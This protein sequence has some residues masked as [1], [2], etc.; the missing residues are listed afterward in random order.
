MP[1]QRIRGTLRPNLVMEIDNQKGAQFRVQ[2]E[3][4]V[5]K[6]TVMELMMHLES[7][8]PEK[9]R[10]AKTTVLESAKKNIPGVTPLSLKIIADSFDDAIAQAQANPGATS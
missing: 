6:N 2:C 7:R 10:A 9:L 4:P 8:N 5:D 1:E 3:V